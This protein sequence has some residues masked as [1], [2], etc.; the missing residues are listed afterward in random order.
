MPQYS[1]QVRTGPSFI[2]NDFVKV[3][4]GRDGAVLLLDKAT[5]TKYEG[6]NFFEDSGD[7]GDEYNYSYPDKDEWCSSG[8]NPVEVSLDENGPLRAAL[9]LVHRLRVPKSASPGEKA[10]SSEKEEFIISTVLSLTR[11]SRRVDIKTTVQNRIKDHRLRVLFATGIHTNETFAD[12]PFAVVRRQHRTYDTREFWIE[13]PAMVAPMQRFVSVSDGKKSFTLIAKGLPEYELKLDQ[14]GVL[15]LTLLRCVGKLSG[16]DL[17][18]RPGGAAGWWNETPEAQCQG[19]HT[20]EY[21]VLPGGLE[22]TDAWSSII[23]EVELFTVPPLVLK[24]KN[25]QSVLE[26]SFVS[27]RPASLML[28]ALKMADETDSIIVRLSNP[29]DRT[30]EGD[31]HFASPVKEAHRA[32]NERRNHRIASGSKRTRSSTYSPAV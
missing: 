15:A 31:I 9:K 4:A 30:V 3:E 19:T 26:E 14:P 22:G 25:N 24:R 1:S 29:V 10:R 13:H 11:S 32:E 17:T 7:V 28:S 16:R 20:F 8:R 2:E 18:T 21:A 12:T 23:P 6:I 27:I 5:G